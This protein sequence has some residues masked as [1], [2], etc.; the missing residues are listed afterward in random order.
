[1]RGRRRAQEILD[2]VRKIHLSTTLSRVWRG[3]AVR[4][5]IARQKRFLQLSRNRNLAA[6]KCQALLR[7]H[8]ARMFTEQILRDRA[9]A[10]QQESIRRFRR[11]R[12]AVTIQC[13]YRAHR[14]RGLYWAA[15]TARRDALLLR[16]LRVATA[17]KL[18]KVVRAKIARAVLQRLQEKEAHRRFVRALTRLQARVQAWKARAVVQL[19]REERQWHEYVCW[20]IAPLAGVGRVAAFGSIALCCRRNGT[21]IYVDVC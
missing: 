12:A 20:R 11:E 8:F 15:V 7:G 4:R 3:A 16:K 21:D 17:I 2:L 9:L 14:S 18:Q 5:E 10:A 19:L 13:M 6:T 1:M